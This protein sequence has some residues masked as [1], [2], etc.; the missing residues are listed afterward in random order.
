[1]LPSFYIIYKIKGG[2]TLKRSILAIAMILMM[3]LTSCGESVIKH[4]VYTEIYERYTKLESYTAEATV[5]VVS[6]LTENEY[7]IRQY[8]QSPNKYRIDVL[9]ADGTESVTYIFSDGTVYMRHQSVDPEIMENYIPNDK[10]YMFIPDFFEG[11]YKSQSTSVT[12]SSSL[13][14]EQ[15]CLNSTLS[16]SNSFRFSQSLWM[17]KKTMLPLKL[18]TYDVNNEPVVTVEFT[19]FKLDEKIEDSEFYI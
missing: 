10:N 1:M 2:F 19:D 7:R 6:N 16:G 15:V 4:D 17:D 11:Y 14:S 5:K 13:G 9:D 12:A 8:Y 3:I 18:V